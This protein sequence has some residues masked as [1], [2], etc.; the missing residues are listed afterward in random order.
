M[1]EGECT[2]GR[3]RVVVEGVKRIWVGTIE[4]PFCL[5][6]VKVRAARVEMDFYGVDC[7]ECFGPLLSRIPTEGYYL[8]LLH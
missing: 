8:S 5:L 6:T 2:M 3:G 1:A 4:I 7:V